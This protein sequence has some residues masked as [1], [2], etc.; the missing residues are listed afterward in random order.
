MRHAE[1]FRPGTD[2]DKR[3]GDTALTNAGWRG[4]LAVGARL[5]DAL[6][7]H[8]LGVKDVTIVCAESQEAGDTAS[9]LVDGLGGSQ[10]AKPLDDLDPTTWTTASGETE[11]WKRILAGS[12]Q[13]EAFV[14]VGHDPQMSWLLHHLVGPRG[15]RRAGQLPLGRGELAMLDGPP[16]GLELQWVLSP[17]DE[18]LIEDLRD[19][20][21]SK[22]DSAKLLGAF[23]TA[24]LVFAARELAVLPEAAGWQ[25]WV[26]GAGL[27]MLAAATAAYF[28]TMFMYDGLLMPVRMW[29]SPK[30]TERELPRGFV[31]RPP[32]SAAWVLY[33]NMMRIWLNAFVPATGLG[34]GGAVLVTIA[35]VRPEDALAWIAVVAAVGGVAACTW[36]IA[37]SARPKLG[38]SD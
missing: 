17:G 9:G 25:L 37:E 38:V 11:R 8:G 24:V 12:G 34:G 28:A 13:T 2:P 23:L 6:P 22:M 5:A 1:A 21:K 18:K 29:P 10:I 14:I 36:F 35:L 30:P 27:T 16:G 33:Q 15:Q 26:G 3:Y 31:R 20:I 19:K 32:S 4:A 7:E